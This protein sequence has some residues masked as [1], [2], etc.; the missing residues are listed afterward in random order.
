MDETNL[1]IANKRQEITTFN[2]N[3]MGES[4]IDVIS[5]TK[6]ADKQVEGG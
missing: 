1:A 5:T 3:D 4:N 6:K 2:R